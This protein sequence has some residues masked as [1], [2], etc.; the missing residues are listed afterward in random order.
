MDACPGKS[1]ENRTDTHTYNMYYRADEIGTD[2][3]RDV[4]KGDHAEPRAFGRSLSWLGRKKTRRTSKKNK[5]QKPRWPP[6]NSHDAPFP[7]V[8]L[9]D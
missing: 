1:L 9:V 6:L 8:A 2:P 3:V 7:S 5:L 4:A